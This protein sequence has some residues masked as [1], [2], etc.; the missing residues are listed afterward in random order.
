MKTRGVA[1]LVEYREEVHGPKVDGSSP[2]PATKNKRFE[3]RWNE[4]LGSPD[5]P[6]LRRYVLTLWG[7]SIRLHFWRASDD[8]RFFHDHAW[9]YVSAVLSGGYTEHLPERSIQR[10][11]GS[12]AS[13]R[14]EHRHKVEM[15]PGEHC[16]TLILTGAMRRKW[17]FWIPGR[18]KPMRPLRYF[19]RYGHH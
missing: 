7:R 6:Y 9:D 3:I 17:G 18:T 1:Q 14:A 10:R 5:A 19:S 11:A 12:V 4:A 8:Q 2:S 13:Y 15:L 16:V